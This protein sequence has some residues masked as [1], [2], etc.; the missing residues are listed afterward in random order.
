MGNRCF[1]AESRVVRVAV[2]PDGDPSAA[3]SHAEF[4]RPFHAAGPIVEAV[5]GKLA[6][7]A[8]TYDRRAGRFSR[9]G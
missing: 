9:P 8:V 5:R 4:C 3:R 6:A 7:H 1:F 2:S